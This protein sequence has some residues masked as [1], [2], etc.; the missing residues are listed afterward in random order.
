LFFILFGFLMEAKEIL[1]PETIVWAIAIV[2]IIIM[3]RWLALKISKFSTSPLLFIAPR[4]LITILLFLA[5]LPE[6]NIPI[7][8]KS[9]IIQTIILSVFVMM[10]GLM[11]IKKNEAH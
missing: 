3:V 10:L 9:L 4:G 5:I 7:V 8:N 11:T 2:F 1:N 6:Q